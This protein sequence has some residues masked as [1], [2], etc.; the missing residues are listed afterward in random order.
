MPPDK[1]PIRRPP[2]LLSEETLKTN[3]PF[4]SWRLEATR[5]SALRH[6]RSQ[7]NKD[8]ARRWHSLGAGVNAGARESPSDGPGA[9][10]REQ[11]GAAWS[12]VSWKLGFPPGG[13]R[14]PPGA[15]LP[16][17]SDSSLPNNG[18]TQSP[19]TRWKLA[20]Q[21][22]LSA[23]TRLKSPLYVSKHPSEFVQQTSLLFY[24]LIHLII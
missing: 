14:D 1:R 12:K 18:K 22:S 23:T 3:G 4:P 5:R 6:T 20:G 19:A 15:R 11:N 10:S 24:L 8:S 13:S 2:S 9:S 17:P 21:N 7:A 16:V